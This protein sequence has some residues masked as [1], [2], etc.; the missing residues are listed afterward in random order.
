VPTTL[1]PRF[2]IRWTAIDDDHLIARCDI[3]AVAVEVHYTIDA[4]GHLVSMVFDRWGDPR[5]TGTWGLYP[6][7][8]EITA[9]STFDGL[10]IPSA[11]RFGW[12]YGTDR[13]SDG[14]FFRYRI[15][16]LQRII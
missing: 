11:G 8:G 16:E 9:Y 13:W 14:E 7:G 4:D 1:L 2:G 12:F 10:T 5:H 6:F 3:D 15:T